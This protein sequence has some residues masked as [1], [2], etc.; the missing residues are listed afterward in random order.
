MTNVLNCG[1]TCWPNARASSGVFE[2]S[3]GRPALVVNL[4]PVNMVITVPPVRDGGLF[5]ATFLRELARQATQFA[6][7]LDPRAQQS[8]SAVDG[9]VVDRPAGARHALHGEFD[10]GGVYH[11]RGV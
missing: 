6:D 4:D 1:V 3:P 11:E 7:Q 10:I 8:A 5:M 9:P 2:L